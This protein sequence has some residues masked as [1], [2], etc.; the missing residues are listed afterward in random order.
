MGFESSQGKPFGGV[1]ETSESVPVLNAEN[2]GEKKKRMAKKQQSTQSTPNLHL[3]E[4]KHNNLGSGVALGDGGNSNSS[5]DNN[6]NSNQEEGSAMILA[7]LAPISK[8]SILDE[9]RKMVKQIAEERKK[10]DA[11]RKKQLAIAEGDVEVDDI[12]AMF[13]DLEA[14]ENGELDLDGDGEGGNGGEGEEE[15]SGGGVEAGGDDMSTVESLKSVEVMID[16]L[17]N[18]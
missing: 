10:A 4:A 6:D 14:A 3:K 7:M 12:E 5:N 17:K 8:P 18:R 2:E 1:L 15:I 16:K 13:K 11:L 9:E